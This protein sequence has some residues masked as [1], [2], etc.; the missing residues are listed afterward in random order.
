[1][2]TKS[3][4]SSNR[5]SYLLTKILKSFIKSYSY[6]GLSIIKCGFGLFLSFCFTES[7][8]NL[9]QPVPHI[10]F[11]IDAIFNVISSI[12]IFYGCF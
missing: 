6:K 11:Y 3:K 10:M 1:M 4:T 12:Q 8:K 9:F 5:F 7:F 2:T